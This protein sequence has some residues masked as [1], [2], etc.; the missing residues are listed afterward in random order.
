M[1][2]H[3][4]NHYTTSH[5]LGK[6]VITNTVL[7]KMH[8][9][10]LYTVHTTVVQVPETCSHILPIVRQRIARHSKLYLVLKLEE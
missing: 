1:L 8:A 2:G 9:L 5:L 10:V 3:T 7:H 6:E 4:S